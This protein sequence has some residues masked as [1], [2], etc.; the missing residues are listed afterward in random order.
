MNNFNK[1]KTYD[2]LSDSL[3]LLDK[4]SIFLSILGKLNQ[5]VNQIIYLVDNNSKDIITI[6]N[7]KNKIIELIELG[8]IPFFSGS[9]ISL[10]LIYN[11]FITLLQEDYS[12]EDL[13]SIRKVNTYICNSLNK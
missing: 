1:I 9:G 2:V 5:S 4:K 8:I 7:Y 11:S 13:E 6:N 12:I 10:A 3:E